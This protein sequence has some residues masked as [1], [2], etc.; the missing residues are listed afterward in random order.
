MCY[1]CVA[2]C[3]HTHT[4]TLVVNISV[5]VHVLESQQPDAEDNAKAEGWFPLL[6]ESGRQVYIY[7]SNKNLDTT[8]IADLNT[9]T[10]HG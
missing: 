1:A 7:S 4:H 3:R 8:R 10:P 6:D 2:I 5:Q 9:L